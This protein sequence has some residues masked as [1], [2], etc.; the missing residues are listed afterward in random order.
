MPPFDPLKLNNASPEKG[1]APLDPGP[2]D[3]DTESGFTSRDLAKSDIQQVKGELGLAD[4]QAQ[5]AEW[6]KAQ[7]STDRIAVSA[8]QMLLMRT[9]HA[10]V[11]PLGGSPTRR[12]G[13]SEMN[14]PFANIEVRMEPVNLS[15]IPRS[16]QR[17][18][19]DQPRRR[20][21]HLDHGETFEDLLRKNGATAELIPSILAA[22]GVKQGESPVTE[23][24]K[25]ILELG[26]SEH[27]DDALRLVRIS[28]YADEQLKAAVAINDSGQFAPVAVKATAP[29][30]QRKPNPTT[31]ATPKAAS[32][33]IRA[34]MRQRSNK[35]YPSR[36]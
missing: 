17:P 29:Q 36:S 15:A 16:P 27:G 12:T 20:L 9:S 10:G 28:V 33:S 21:A 11:D 35:I 2:P 14:A 26:D 22:F 4:A 30:P 13:S 6:M 8:P 3:D 24:Q 32:V 34:S 18:N 5:V 19:A 1:D 25:I 23:G 31:T 7:N